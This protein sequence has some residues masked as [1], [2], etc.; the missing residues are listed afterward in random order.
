MS[1]SY[2]SYP[3]SS[4]SHI[5]HTPQS[6]QSPQSSVE[7]SAGRVR[8]WPGGLWLS[9]RRW[10]GGGRDHGRRRFGR[11]PATANDT[12]TII[13]SSSIRR[14]RVVSGNSGRPK[15]NT[16]CALS[17]RDLFLASAPRN[18]LVTV[19]HRVATSGMFLVLKHHEIN[20][21]QRSEIKLNDI[22]V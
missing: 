16:H 9:R 21:K 2:T 17:R 19:V 11:S 10:Y 20:C 3:T 12:I 6:F 4:W 14:C 15:Y 18:T 13:V 7:Q 5:L 8:T 22:M 1:R